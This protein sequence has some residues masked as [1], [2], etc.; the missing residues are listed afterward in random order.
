MLLQSFIDKLTKHF[1]NV[2]STL[3]AVA[4]GSIVFEEV[5]LSQSIDLLMAGIILI[6]TASLYLS[7]EGNNE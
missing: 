3:T 2:G 1:G 4:L 6:V 5:E 7:K